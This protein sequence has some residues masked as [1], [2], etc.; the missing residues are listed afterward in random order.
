MTIKS[1]SIQNTLSI[2]SSIGSLIFGLILAASSLVIANV[3]VSMG[4][5]MP[6]L[7]VVLS[8]SVGLFFCLVGVVGLLHQ[9][10]LSRTQTTGSIIYPYLVTSSYK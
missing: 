4:E 9:R 10:G 6:L 7:L 8:A 2:A 3:H 1:I 5:T